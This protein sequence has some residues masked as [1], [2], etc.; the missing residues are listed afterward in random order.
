MRLT[1][2][3]MPPA[4]MHGSALTF[5]GAS[6]Q[7]NVTTAGLP[8]AAV[9]CESVVRL[10]WVSVTS[11]N[12]TITFAQAGSLAAGAD[13]ML[14]VAAQP[15]RVAITIRPASVAMIL[16]KFFIVKQATFVLCKKLTP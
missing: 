6:P 11:G 4:F 8:Q 12:R 15:A 5:I 7:R 2:Q 9:P 1:N 13:S 16:R 3:S 10:A 14:T